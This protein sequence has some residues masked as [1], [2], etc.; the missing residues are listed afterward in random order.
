[1]YFDK[2]MT[3]RDRIK[4]SFSPLLCESLS[5][6]INNKT[7]NFFIID[8]SGIKSTSE[9]EVFQP[10]LTSSAQIILVNCSSEIQHEISRELC[11]ESPEGPTPMYSK[12]EGGRVF[13]K[14]DVYK[15]V[16]RI[17]TK[18][19]TGI[20]DYINDLP[21]NLIGEFISKKSF[22]PK[23]VLLPSSN[24]YANAYINIKS[25]FA[26][27]LH[28][29]YAVVIM[30]ARIELFLKNFQSQKVC[31]VCASNNGAIIMENLAETFDDIDTIDFISVGPQVAL[32]DP[33][34]F[35]KISRDCVYVFI[36]DF[37]C[38]GTELK[39]TRLLCTLKDA[40]IIGSFG[41]AE[42][43]DSSNRSGNSR[44]FGAL[45]HINRLPQKNFYYIAA[46]L[47]DL[48]KLAAVAKEC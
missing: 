13:A 28:Y 42:Y 9:R 46:T 7:A 25:L 47:D 37:L 23:V 38:L 24:V 43:V 16:M 44:F 35:E 15:S 2:D 30:H 12:Y 45:V 20:T 31:F 39:L 4:L 32:H 22:I 17:L 14:Q 41:I 1:M 33:S 19:S 29:S 6:F 3:I 36:Y 8:F 5:G 21:Q 10:F 27:H 34:N 18:K 26:D 40:K 48:N 11:P